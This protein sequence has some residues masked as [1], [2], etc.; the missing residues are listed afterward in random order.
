[1]PWKRTHFAN[2]GLAIG[3]TCHVSVCI[4][5]ATGQAG[6]AGSDVSDRHDKK[7]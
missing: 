1:M 6:N 5:M 2:D 7:L 4:V 3:R